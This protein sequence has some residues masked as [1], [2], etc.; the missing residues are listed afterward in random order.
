MVPGAQTIGDVAR[1]EARR[2]HENGPLRLFHGHVERPG[3]LPLEV[4]DIP[5]L[6]RPWQPVDLF[7]G[8]GYEKL[9]R[10][11]RGLPRTRT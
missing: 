7:D 11:L 1:L 10:A 3:D 8:R 6:L 2:N 5:D 4:C 9:L